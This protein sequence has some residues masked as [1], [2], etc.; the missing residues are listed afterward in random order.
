LFEVT[1]A[2]LNL[3]CGYLADGSGP[4]D[5]SLAMKALAADVILLQEVWHPFDRP[6]LVA[7]AAMSLSLAMLSHPV[8]TTDLHSL[9]V[10]LGRNRGTWGLVILSRYPIYSHRV[11]ELGTA[12]GDM[13]GR[14]AQV[15]DLEICAGGVLRVVNTH[16]T[17]RVLASPGQLRRL[18][19]E[20]GRPDILAGDLNMVGPVATAVS[21][22]RRAACSRSW[23]ARR[24]AVQLDHIL[25]AERIR[26][27]ESGT[28][29]AVGS[30]HLPV[31]ARLRIA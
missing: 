17:H 2:T 5:V 22:M 9:G 18:I 12:S 19:A 6:D 25:V 1:V 23:P 30:D 20:V 14:A 21:R 26:S 7:E 16:L 11:V 3:H 15:A 24:P 13:T 27:T 28:L 4:F 31:R 10:G 29:D 8:L